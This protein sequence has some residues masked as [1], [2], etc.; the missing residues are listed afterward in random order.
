MWSAGPLATGIWIMVIERKAV[1][2]AD[3]RTLSAA[4]ME[5]CHG[6]L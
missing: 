6:Y 2:D 5:G 4:K 3:E 1:T